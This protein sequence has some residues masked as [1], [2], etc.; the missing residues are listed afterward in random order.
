MCRVAEEA[1]T[2]GAAVKLAVLR[3]HE[4]CFGSIYMNSPFTTDSHSQQYVNPLNYLSLFHPMIEGPSTNLYTPIYVYIIFSSLPTSL[5]I[6]LYFL[7][8][9]CVRLSCSSIIS[10]ITL[11]I[12]RPIPTLKYVQ[13]LFNNN[14]FHPV[15]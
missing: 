10:L 9:I 13:V 5:H 8:S 14:K 1:E 12:F 7:Y 4:P 11:M 15:V 6:T 3:N 2:I